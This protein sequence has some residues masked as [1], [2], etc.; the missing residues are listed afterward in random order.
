MIQ[1]VDLLLALV[2]I[3]QQ[4]IP[5]FRQEA[6]LSARFSCLPQLK[7][8]F[9]LF[10]IAS[11]ILQIPEKQKILFLIFIQPDCLLSLFSL[12]NLP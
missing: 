1:T 3:F 12:F 10:R 11:G 7:E 9:Y 8:L 4:E 6:Q 2:K 5:L